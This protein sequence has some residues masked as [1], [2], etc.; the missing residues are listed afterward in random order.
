MNQI[1]TWNCS[2]F[3]LWCSQD[4]IGLW[5]IW[6]IDVQANEE[7]W[8]WFLAAFSFQIN[9]GFTSTYLF[10][11]QPMGGK[12]NC[13]IVPHEVTGIGGVEKNS[14]PITTKWRWNSLHHDETLSPSSF[15][16]T[17][18]SRFNYISNSL[19]TCLFTR[20]II[21]W[22][23]RTKWETLW[24]KFYLMTNL[25][26]NSFLYMFISILYMF[27]A[28]K[29]PSSGDSIVSIRYLVYVTLCRWPSA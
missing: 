20:V 24:E 4:R 27:R 17:S 23:V 16:I 18:Y 19:H 6:F 8:Q 2:D 5:L 9:S 22:S 12:C 29:C 25:M 11:F 14:G 26:H 15:Q 1:L 3:K 10:F 28:F 13:S 21:C 7:L